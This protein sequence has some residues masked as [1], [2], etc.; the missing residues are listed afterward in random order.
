MSG[1]SI[2]ALARVRSGTNFRRKNIKTSVTTVRRV[3]EEAGYRPP[4]TKRRNA[5]DERYEAIRPNH[6]W[7]LDYVHRHIHRASTFSLILIDDHSRYVVGHGIDEKSSA[8]I[9]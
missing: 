1:T 5:H 8:P 7:H 6:M 4:K 9:F 2:L 3:M